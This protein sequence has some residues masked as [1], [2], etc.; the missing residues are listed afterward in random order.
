MIQ[1]KVALVTGGGQGIGKAIASQFLAAGLKV[2]IAEIDAEAGQETAL[3]YRSLGEIHWIQ[4]DIASETEVKRA[5]ALP[6][7]LRED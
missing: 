6:L 3:E 4:T 7:N 5:I 1:A 2:A